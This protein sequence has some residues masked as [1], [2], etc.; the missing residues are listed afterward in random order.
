MC[1]P[2]RISS[3]VDPASRDKYVFTRFASAERYC[4]TFPVAR[5][6]P[7]ADFCEYTD[8]SLLAPAVPDGV[9][10]DRFT[11]GVRQRRRD[12]LPGPAAVVRDPRVHEVFDAAAT[13]DDGG[14]GKR[15][16]VDLVRDVYPVYPLDVDEIHR[17]A[18]EA[19]VASHG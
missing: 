18:A 14:V 5:M 11:L 3:H 13:A 10:P 7:G 16:A 2:L 8:P 12:R 17:A 1:G 6:T 15:A 19:N 4:P 9:T